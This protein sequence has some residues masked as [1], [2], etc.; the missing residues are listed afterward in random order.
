[1]SASNHG[2]A[3]LPGQRPT[4]YLS[5]Y[6]LTQFLKLYAIR[7]EQQRFSIFSYARNPCPEAVWINLESHFTDFEAVIRFWHG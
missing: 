4:I 3:S 5:L 7:F 2:R 1:M 6:F